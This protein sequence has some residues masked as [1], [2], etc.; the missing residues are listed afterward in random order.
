[1]LTRVSLRL[2]LPL[3]CCL[4]L[5]RIHPMDQN[6]ARSIASCG[7]LLLHCLREGSL[8]KNSLINRHLVDCVVEN[9]QAQVDACVRV[10]ERRE[11]ARVTRF[12][13][14]IALDEHL[15]SR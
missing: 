6:L 7:P 8:L 2:R 4:L 1:M 13:T 15:C 14:S 9:P 3:H 5:L 12:H 10:R 11:A